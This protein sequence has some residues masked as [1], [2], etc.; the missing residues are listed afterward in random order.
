MPCLREWLEHAAALLSASAPFQGTSASSPRREAEMLL[1]H[2]LGMTRESLVTH[3]RDPLP[4]EAEQRLDA[5]IAR[6]AEGEPPAYLVGEKEFY[7]RNFAV[8]P[9]TLIP[10]PETEH[11]VDAA[12]FLLGDARP[13][14]PNLP[15]DGTT[16][17]LSARTA[18]AG[19]EQLRFLDLGTGSGC[20]ALTLAAECPLWRGLAVDISADALEIARANARRLGVADR[21]EFLQADFCAPDFLE[22]LP[23]MFRSPGLILSN[24]PYIGEREY[25]ELE[26][27]VRD[28]EPETALLAGPE[29]LE[30]PRAVLAAAKELLSS[31][32]VLLM[33]HGAGQGSAIRKMCGDSWN[34]ALTGRDYAGLER[35]LLAVRA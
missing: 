2:A 35:Y 14:L 5:L 9:A 33:E 26:R 12:L 6:R 8:S 27:G 19:R 4:A 21:V 25:R 15:V 17:L 31:G 13:L 28:F 7:G 10:R 16:A 22:R 30:H 29:G 3:D 1:C 24:P 34:P 23:E 20:I 32:G 11:L 18:R